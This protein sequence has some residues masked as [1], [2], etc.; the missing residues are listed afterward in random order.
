MID[1][2]SWA[3]SWYQEKASAEVIREALND[4]PEGTFVIRDD[5]YNEDQ[6]ILNY[7]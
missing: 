7:R 6:F 1:D 2:A 3:A 4:R 5:P